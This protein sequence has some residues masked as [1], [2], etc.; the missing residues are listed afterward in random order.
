MPSLQV[1]WEGGVTRNL[2]SCQEGHFDK[3]AFSEH[4]V[5][6][7]RENQGINTLTS[8]FS[9]P[10]LGA[11]CFGQTQIEAKQPGHLLI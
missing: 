7:Q 4:D 11:L 5:T 8:F 10:S 6:L 1:A 9:F 3:L 2:E